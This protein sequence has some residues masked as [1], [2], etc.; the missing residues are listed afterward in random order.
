MIVKG[1]LGASMVQEKEVRQ[2]WDSAEND[3]RARYV[4]LC[5]VFFNSF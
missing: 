2:E 4:R 1:R 5:I 3:Q